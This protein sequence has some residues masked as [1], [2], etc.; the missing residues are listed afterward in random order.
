[1]ISSA[2]PSKGPCFLGRQPNHECEALLGAPQCASNLTSLLLQ[3]SKYPLLPFVH[4][5]TT[6]QGIKPLMLVY[7]I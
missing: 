5:E 3:F 7:M 1:M 6:A 2:G 4:V